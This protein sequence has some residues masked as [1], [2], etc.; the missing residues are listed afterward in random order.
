MRQEGDSA[1]RGACR[2][3]G[4]RQC[5]RPPRGVMPRQTS[6]GREGYINTAKAGGSLPWEG[7]QALFCC[8]TCVSLQFVGQRRRQFAQGGCVRLCLRPESL[9]P[10]I[11]RSKRRRQVPVVLGFR[12]SPHH[13]KTGVAEVGFWQRRGI[14][15]FFFF[16]VQRDKNKYSDQEL[17]PAS[18]CVEGIQSQVGTI[19]TGCSQGGIATDPHGWMCACSADSTERT[20][21]TS[22]CPSLPGAAGSSARGPPPYSIVSSHQLTSKYFLKPR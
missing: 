6:G 12:P 20:V 10:G 7:Q 8:V 4:V 21:R 13:L 15:F 14:F 2:L 19:P 11:G 1:H 9:Y 22:A 3:T 16:L 18:P 5:P 17:C